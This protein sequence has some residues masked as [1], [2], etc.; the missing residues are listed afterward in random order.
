MIKKTFRLL[1]LFV[2]VLFF[3]Y[4]AFAQSVDSKSMEMSARM[5]A[6][7]HMTDG[8]STRAIIRD[9]AIINGNRNEY[10]KFCNK[11]MRCVVND[12]IPK[13]LHQTWLLYAFIMAEQY[14][15]T[16]AAFDFARLIENIDVEIDSS[17]A[18]R[19]IRYYEMSSK[20]KPDNMSF[21]A[22]HRLFLIY[23]KGLYGIPKNKE[24]SE[25]YD[26]LCDTIVKSI[27]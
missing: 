22:A 9:I 5:V 23:G 14:Q 16:L 19:I 17:M 13:E 15:D 12:T 10:L 4:P 21:F 25:F 6:D 26:K 24:K 20:R 18:A 11:C 27:K 7:G 2:L 1:V 3:A 8:D